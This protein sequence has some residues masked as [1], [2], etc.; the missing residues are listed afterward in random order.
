MF[1]IKSALL[2]VSESSEFRFELD[3]S[4]KYKISCSSVNQIFLKW[5][6]NICHTHTQAHIYR[7]R[8]FVKIVMKILKKLV[9]NIQRSLNK[10]SYNN[11]RI[12]PIFDSTVHQ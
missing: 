1:T 8:D 4:L 3:N 2:N 7:E 5:G 9:Q 10:T 12:L 6:H 11:E